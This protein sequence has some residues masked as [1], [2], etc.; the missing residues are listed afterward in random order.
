MILFSFTKDFDWL[1]LGKCRLC[2]LVTVA[3][4]RGHVL[5]VAPEVADAA[6]AAGAGRRVPTDQPYA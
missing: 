3:F 5:P 6:E 1:T 4:K 2:K